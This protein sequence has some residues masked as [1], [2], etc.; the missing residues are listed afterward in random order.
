MVSNEQI[1]DLL[2]NISQRLSNLEQRVHHYDEAFP[3]PSITIEQWLDES[4]VKQ[5]YI[6]TLVSYNE[7]FMDA[8][9]QFISDNHCAQTL[10]MY[11]QKKRL[12][13]PCMENEQIQWKLMEHAFEKFMREI[14]RK[15]VKYTLDNPFQGIH[16]DIVDI[17]KQKIMGMN[18]RVCEVQKNRREI[19]KWLSCLS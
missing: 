3:E 6:D 11:I 9:K 16:D 19:Q 8:L 15:F 17:Y 4:C 18:R 7:G 10:P 1:Y 5:S 12:Y 14:W 13:V 2:L